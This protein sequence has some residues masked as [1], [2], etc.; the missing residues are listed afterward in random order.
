LGAAASGR[1]AVLT[2]RAASDGG[3]GDH[4][5]DL[6]AAARAAGRTTTSST[7]IQQAL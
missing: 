3:Q 6:G 2:V 4:S 1:D 7:G 5:I